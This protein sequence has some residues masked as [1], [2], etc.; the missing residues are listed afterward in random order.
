[1]FRCNIWG[2]ILFSEK[3]LRVILCPEFQRL[4]N[5]KQ[6]GLCSLKFP[7]AVGNRFEHSL[8]TGWISNRIGTTLLHKYPARV[9]NKHVELITLAGLVHDI[10]HGPLSH[11]FDFL[12]QT[13]HE[14]R[15]KEVIK[16]IAP[17]LNLDDVDVNTICSMIT[18][19]FDNWLYQI[20]SSKNGIDSDRM[21]YLIRDST[22]LNANVPLTK[23]MVLRM[24]DSVRIT[25][26]QLTFDYRPKAFLDTRR[27]MF[28]KYY[29]HPDVVALERNPQLAGLFQYS[30]LSEFLELNEEVLLKI[31]CF[32]Q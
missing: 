2:E 15:S 23:N 6:L 5:I 24:I 17:R 28:S 1:M 13:R 4:R 19:D 32:N 27:I 9:T 21:D 30:N 7:K 8:G 22:Y 26:E 12:T 14:D 31:N 16:L 29:R 20:V 18:G 3:H 11:V 10:G 25:N